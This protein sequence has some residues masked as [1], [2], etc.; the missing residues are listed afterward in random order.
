MAEI[1][2]LD[3]FTITSGIISHCSNCRGKMGAGI[4]LEIRKRFPVVYEKYLKQCQLGNFKIGT[5]QIVKIKSDLYVCNMAGQD[6]YG[7]DKRYLDYDALRLCLQKLNAWANYRQL[8]IYLPFKMGC[9]SAGGN[10]GIVFNIIEEESPSAI[11]C[12][13]PNSKYR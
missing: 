7:R 5:I 2:E 6:R 4:A 13:I 9:C 8:Q 1:K 12:R 10:W 11:I 3:I